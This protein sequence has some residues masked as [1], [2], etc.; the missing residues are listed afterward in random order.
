MTNYWTITCVVCGASFTQ[1]RAGKPGRKA[2]MC[3]KMICFVI[4]R[5]QCKHKAQPPAK[6]LQR[7]QADLGDR[8][9]VLRERTQYYKKSVSDD[10]RA[11]R[12]QTEFV[13][14][15]HMVWVA[16]VRKVAADNTDLSWEMLAERFGVDPSQVRRECRDIP[17]ERD[18]FAR[19]WARV[20]R[21]RAI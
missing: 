8:K 20:H 13:R 9:R 10:S 6:L 5:Y 4:R 18:M 19:D 7:W 12:E 1:Y 3:E 14:Q 15:Q 17:R 11:Q 2:V 21:R 16:R